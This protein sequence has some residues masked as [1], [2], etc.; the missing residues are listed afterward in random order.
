M[1][2]ISQSCPTLCNPMDYSSP[3]SSIHGVSPGKNTGVGC[4]TL[5]QGIFT[6]QGSNPGLPYCRQTLYHLSHRGHLSYSII[7]PNIVDNSPQLCRAMGRALKANSSQLDD[8]IDIPYINSNDIYKY[9]EGCI[10]CHRASV[11]QFKPFL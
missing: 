8:K 1:C 2:L 5:L 10:I 9:L 6:T 4:H 11:S 3:G 7:Y